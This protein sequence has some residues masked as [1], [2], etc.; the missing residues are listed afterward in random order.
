MP[1]CAI[2]EPVLD[3]YS[4]YKGAR[5]FSPA[6]VAGTTQTTAQCTLTEAEGAEGAEDGR[7]MQGEEGY[8]PTPPRIPAPREAGLGRPVLASASDPSAAEP[9]SAALSHAQPASA[10]FSDAARARARP[11]RGHALPARSARAGKKI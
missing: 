6:R 9:P 8:D 2:S 4:G 10:T 5:A 11:H 7:D 1:V 3:S